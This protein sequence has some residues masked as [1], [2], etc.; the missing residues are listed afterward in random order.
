MPTLHERI[1]TP[2]PIDEAFAFVADFANALQ[3]GSRR[4]HVRAPRRGP[5][6]PSGARYRLG[7]PDGRPR[8]ARWS[9]AITAFEPPRRVVLTGDRVGRRPPS[10]TSGSRPRPTGTRID[11]TARHP[12]PRRPGGSSSPLLGAPSPRWRQ[13]TRSV[14]CSARSTR[15]PRPRPRR[16]GRGHRHRRVRRQRPHR[17]LRPARVPPRSPCSSRTPVAGRPRQDRAGRDDGR[18][19]RGRHRLHRLQRAHLPAASSACSPSSASR[20]SRATCR[21]DRPADACGI[22]FSSRGVARLLRRADRRSLARPVADDRRHPPLL[23]RGSRDA[24]RARHPTGRPSGDFLDDGGYGRGFRATS[25]SPSRPPSGRRRAPGSSTSR[26][27]TC[28]A[29]STT[30]ASSAT[31][32][33][34]QWR[35]DPGRLAGA[36]STG[37]SPPLPPGTV[38]SGS[39]VVGRRRAT[40]PVSPSSPRTAPRSASTPSS[41]PR[42]PTRLCASSPT[43]TS[44]ERPALG[45]FEYSTNQVVLHTDER[46]PARPTSGAGPRGTS[47]PADCRAAGRRADDDLPHEPAAVAGRARRSTASR[48]IR[49]DRVRPEPVIVERAMSHPMYTFR[50]LERAGRPARAAGPASDTWFAGRPPRLR[51]PR[52]RLPLRA[53]RSPSCSGRERG[54]RRVN[55]HLLEGNGPPSPRSGRS[56]TS[57]STTSSTSPS[58][59]PSSTRCTRRLRLVGR[60][61]PSLRRLPRRRPPARAGHDVPRRRPRAHL[62][63]RGRRPERL[64]G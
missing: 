7:R 59:S 44:R 19:G 22:A 8:R 47:T 37:S 62:R 33:P 13:R 34:S 39:P 5:G 36:T 60:N 26:S 10:T 3:L 35:V 58:T 20:R 17:G 52:G 46:H 31:A 23:P 49:G 51:L 6:R 1:E 56:S 27:T 64:A 9:T 53:S 63:G 14:A 25:S 32:T 4:R 43:P 61:R 48:S 41:W 18:T 16:T 11:Y 24:R 21:S 2:L 55:S 54:A 40:R 15:A 38:R 45:G 30:T 28:S 42:M 50:T 12:A 57:S 29:S